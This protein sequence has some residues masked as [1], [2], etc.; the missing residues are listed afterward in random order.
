MCVCV[1]VSVMCV[2]L[3]SVCVCVC[4][5]AYICVVCVCDVHV[6][7]FQA[8]EHLLQL[9]LVRPVD[10]GACKVQ[11]EYQLMR[12]MLEH[13]QVMEAL[14]RYPQCPTDVKQWALSAFA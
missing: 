5:C 9:E 10:S 1:C 7:V 8:F 13:G 4:V 3:M 14:Q 12:L 2:S 6:C 11:R